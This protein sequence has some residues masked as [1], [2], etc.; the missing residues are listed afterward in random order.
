VQES[1]EEIIGRVREFRASILVLANRLD[2]QPPGDRN[3]R[4]VPDSEQRD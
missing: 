3:L 4:L 1:V 2:A